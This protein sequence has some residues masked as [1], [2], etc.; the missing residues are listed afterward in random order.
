MEIFNI[1]RLLNFLSFL[2]LFGIHF[3]SN[4][5]ESQ[6]KPDRQNFNSTEEEKDFMGK[7]FNLFVP[8]YDFQ[9]PF[10]FR[11]EQ[12]SKVMKY[13]S[14]H[15]RKLEIPKDIYIMNEELIAEYEENYKKE[16]L[17]RIINKEVNLEEVVYDENY[18]IYAY[19]DVNEF[20][21]QKPKFI[22][23]EDLKLKNYDTLGK[24]LKF[25]HRKIEII[26]K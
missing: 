4:C 14:D 24:F 20:K 2:V 16:L 19:P 9:R 1:L 21:K 3:K 18:E 25:S 10:K 8:I 17:H 13:A 23:N 26:D 7:K 12:Y 5:N 11:K 22:S 15:K 6:K